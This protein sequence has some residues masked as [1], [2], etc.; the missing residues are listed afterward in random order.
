[1]GPVP[2]VATSPTARDWWG[3]VL[4]RIGVTRNNY[5]INPGLYAVG[6]PGPLSPVLVTANYKLSFDALRFELSGVSAWILVA[7]TRGINVWCAAGKGTFS[8]DEMVSLVKWARLD[9]VI[10]HDTLIVPQLGAVG[11]SAPRVKKECGFRVRFGPVRARDIPAFLGGDDVATESMRSV[12]FTLGERAELIPVEVYLQLKT[13]AVTLGVG[14][15]LAGL[16]PHFFAIDVTWH[17]TVQL[18]WSTLFGIFC[19]SALVPLLLPWI[20]GRQFWIKG[21]WPPLMLGVIILVS[22]GW[23]FSLNHAA[24][25]L[26]SVVISSYQAMNFTGCT[27]FTSPSGVEFEMRRG[28]PVQGVGGGLA[29]LLWLV[30]PFIG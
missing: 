23:I 13:I 5:R 16:G 26:W 29:I 10:T 21:L 14:F 7:D 30:S 3:R 20:P 27:P 28:I 18:F 25:L 22:G 19:G 4:T 15:L 11:V 17:R 12:T 9:Q 1:M 24:L 8:T 6:S 2:R